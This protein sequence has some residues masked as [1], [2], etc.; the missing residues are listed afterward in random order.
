MSTAIRQEV[1]IYIQEQNNNFSIK[2][3]T[4]DWTSANT[5]KIGEKF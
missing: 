2:E 1:K 4:S 5:K 3:K